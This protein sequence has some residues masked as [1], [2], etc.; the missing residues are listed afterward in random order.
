MFVFEYLSVI[1]FYKL[2]VLINVLKDIKN[3]DFK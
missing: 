2:V 3:L 1:L